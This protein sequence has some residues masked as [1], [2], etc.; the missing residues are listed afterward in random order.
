MGSIKIS[1][2]G[3][4][5]GAVAAIDDVSLEIR[6]GEF[7]TLLGPSGC[8][9]TTTLRAIAGLADVDIGR[10]EIG[11]KD[12]TDL[13][14]HR[15]NIGM[16][17]QNHALFPHMTVEQNVS[18]GLRMRSVPVK[19]QSERSRTA[20]EL[21]HLGG[22]GGRYPHQLSGGQQQRVALARALVIE[23]E[24]LLLDEPFGA[25]DRK[26]RESMQFELRQ[27]TRRLGVTSVFVTHDQEEAMVLSDRIA[28]M[29]GGRVEQLG[30]P[31][32]I[33]ERP[34]SR[35]VADFMGITNV[36]T[37]HVVT[38][39]DGLVGLDVDGISCSARSRSSMVVGQRCCVT[40]RS[41]KIRVS[42]TAPPAGSFAVEG[43]LEHSIYLGTT[44]S[45]RVRLKVN[46]AVVLSAIEVNQ[47][48]IAHGS[49]L[50]PGSSVWLSWVREAVHAFEDDGK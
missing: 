47:A 3:K 38:V 44:S 25:L 42:E 26:L 5:F 1:G 33:F 20:L 6:A 41:E 2:I 49:R 48:D 34:S 15:R 43:V 30:S 21:V 46:Q 8:G 22:F 10:I 12:V 35:F 23:P 39:A 11:G 32:E 28:V 31:A 4:R 18:F 19:S 50:S 45:Y 37:G 9:K 29:N 24:V 14:V 7:L 13:P 36:L 16:V 27:L 40:I 17:F